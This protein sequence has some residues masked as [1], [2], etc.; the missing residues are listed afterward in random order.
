M[1]LPAVDGKP[2]LVAY[3]L[4]SHI[5]GNDSPLAHAD[6][7]QRS[8]AAGDIARASLDDIQDILAVADTSLPACYRVG[9]VVF[10]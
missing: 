9:P 1:H 8:S 4:Y 10:S 3:K 7:V 2:L 6:R 5:P